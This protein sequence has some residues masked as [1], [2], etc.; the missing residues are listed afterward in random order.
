MKLY[1]SPKRARDA[2]SP[3]GTCGTK[4]GSDSNLSAAHKLRMHVTEY[5]GLPKTLFPLDELKMRT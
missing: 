1:L 4:G 5:A 2:L 3:G